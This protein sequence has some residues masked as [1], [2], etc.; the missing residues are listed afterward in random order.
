M[1]GSSAVRIEMPG[2]AV[3]RAAVALLVF[4]TIGNAAPREARAQIVINSSS[5]SYEFA[6]FDLA[7]GEGTTPIFRTT[8]NAL[9]YPGTG[10]SEGFF[11]PILNTE[12]GMVQT[13]TGQPIAPSAFRANAV[14]S[15]IGNGTNF[16]AAAI[17]AQAAVSKAGTNQ[18]ANL[19]GTGVFFN[20]T[21]FTTSS[22][23]P[24]VASVSIATATSVFQNNGSTVQARPGSVLSVTTT[25][26]SITDGSYTAA[27]LVSTLT[28][29]NPGVAPVAFDL[30]RLVMAYRGPG[31]EINMT[32]DTTNPN[33][34]TGL[35]SLALPGSI[36]LMNGGRITLTST[37]TLISDPDS[38]IAITD[39]TQDQ[40]A[41][42]DLPDFGVYAGD[43]FAVPEP[44]P[45]V[46]AAVGLA[47]FALIRGAVAFRRRS[48]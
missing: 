18:G 45:P 12:Q 14:R 17:E 40:M 4:L 23:A 9:L 27:G 32:A 28:V 31:S 8:D 16:G 10:G 21:S 6:V 5:S 25:L 2:P 42:L 47:C 37:I 34:A 41:G 26:G 22:S 48:S 38:F 39:P 3:W 44:S 43:I 19:R 24:N 20:S 7:F 36:T 35:L 1:N 13:I 11:Y 30:G 33:K 29:Q 46:L 15:Q